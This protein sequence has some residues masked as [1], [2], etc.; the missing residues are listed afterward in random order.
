MRLIL[1]MT[2]LVTWMAGLMPVY[3]K[4]MNK[5]YKSFRDEGT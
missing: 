1:I 3:A 4:M 2:L 5:I